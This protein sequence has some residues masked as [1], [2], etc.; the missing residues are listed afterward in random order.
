MQR[1]GRSCSLQGFPGAT[2]AHSGSRTHVS[3]VEGR[4]KEEPGLLSWESGGGGGVGGGFDPRPAARNGADGGG[5]E[6]AGGPAGEYHVD[7]APMFNSWP[8][9]LTSCVTLDKLLTLSES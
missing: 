5:V 7:F 9:H 3:W 2:V 8:C 4:K 6:R 1:G